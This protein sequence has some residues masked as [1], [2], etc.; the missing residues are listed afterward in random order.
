MKN[1]PGTLMMYDDG[2]EF[3]ISFSLYRTR[4]SYM[5]RFQYYWYPNE[6]YC[7]LHESIFTWI[8]CEAVI[9]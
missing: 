6:S 4:E 9:A 3:C 7:A 8:N 2:E 5:T 1:D